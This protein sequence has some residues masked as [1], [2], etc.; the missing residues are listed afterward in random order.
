MLS[1]SHSGLC[2]CWLTELVVQLC[3]RATTSVLT[4]DSIPLCWSFAR[5]LA[6]PEQPSSMLCLVAEPANGL[7]LFPIYF[8][9]IKHHFNYCNNSTIVTFCTCDCMELSL[10]LSLSYFF[11]LICQKEKESRL[12]KLNHEQELKFMNYAAG[13]VPTYSVY[14]FLFCSVSKLMPSLLYSFLLVIHSL[15]SV[16]HPSVFYVNASFWWLLRS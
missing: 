13:T 7:I 6:L 12:D 10:L 14:F 15:D 5:M 2:L 4:T 9:S 1:I 8:I 11:L 16:M 3:S